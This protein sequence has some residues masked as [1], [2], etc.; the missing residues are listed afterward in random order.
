MKKSKNQINKKIIESHGFT[1]KKLKDGWDVYRHTPAGEGWC[2]FFRKL[3][4]IKE[5]GYSYDPEEEFETLYEAG[6]HG[7]KGVPGP[8]ELWKDQL[9]KQAIL[10]EIATEIEE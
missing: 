2:L 9:W 10:M 6:R 8:G 4:D 7:F 5:Y 1:V 3:S